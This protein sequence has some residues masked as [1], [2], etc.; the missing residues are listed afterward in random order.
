MGLFGLMFTGLSKTLY[1]PLVNIV[2]NTKQLLSLK[3]LSMLW[4]GIKTVAGGVA[5]LAKG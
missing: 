2:K 1:S 5:S 4:G 3:Y